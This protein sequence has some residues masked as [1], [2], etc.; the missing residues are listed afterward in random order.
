MVTQTVIYKIELEIWGSHPEKNWRPKN[1]K[2]LARFRTTSRHDR[3]YLRTGTRYCRSENGVANCGH[4]RT[5]LP[6]LVNFG[7]QTEK[8][9]TGVST[10]LKLTFSDAHI[11]G[12]KGCG[13]LKIIKI[14]NLVQD[15]ERML[16]HTS[17]GMGLPPTVSKG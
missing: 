2:I 6:N 4:S 17:L 15:N 9:R 5:C 13:P 11:L 16:T 8:K 14:S 1:I 10:H 7:T 12:A 3:E